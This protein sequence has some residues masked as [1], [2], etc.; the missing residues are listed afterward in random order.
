MNSSRR[1]SAKSSSLSVESREPPTTL[2]H[3]RPRRYEVVVSLR[4]REERSWHDRGRP[5][6]DLAKPVVAGN[7]WSSEY[8]RRHVGPAEHQCLERR[9]KLLTVTVITRWRSQGPGAGG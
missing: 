2:R 9:P 5:S 8:G 4:A 3:P 6:V 7:N 1:P